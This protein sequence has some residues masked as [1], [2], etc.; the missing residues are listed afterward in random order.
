MRATWLRTLADRA[1][2]EARQLGGA[3]EG[4]ECDRG[5]HRRVEEGIEVLV[6]E[7]R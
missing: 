3:D 2:A 1:G 7:L 6:G 4:A 5:I